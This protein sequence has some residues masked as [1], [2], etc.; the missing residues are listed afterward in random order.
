MEV[1]SQDRDTNKLQITLTNKLSPVN[2]TGKILQISYEKA[3]NTFVLNRSDEENPYIKVLDINSGKLEVELTTQAISAQGKLSCAISLIEGDSKITFPS[4]N[5]FVKENFDND[6]AMQSASEVALLKSLADGTN[7]KL[8]EV[9][10]NEN[11]RASSEDT[12]KN[13]E[14]ERVNNEN[15]R[16]NNELTRE[17]NENERVNAESTRKL[18]EEERINHFNSIVD[19]LDETISTEAYI[20]DEVIIDVASVSEIISKLNDLQARIIALENA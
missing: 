17:S 16:K 19:L 12:R 7:A 3:D 18:N 2:L 9:D 8:N 4:F 11:L 13:S 15:I 5:I 14:N 6:N 1:V 20:D 10:A